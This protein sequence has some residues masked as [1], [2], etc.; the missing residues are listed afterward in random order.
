MPIQLSRYFGVD[1]AELKSRGVFNAYLGIDNKLF[2]DPNL[3]KKKL[4]ILEFADSRQDV[5]KYFSQV[6]KLLNASKS[7]GDLAW[8]E[9]EKRLTFREEHGAALGYANAGGFGRA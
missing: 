2:V 6:I 1:P 3:L 8:Q 4:K 9:A 7:E 5:T